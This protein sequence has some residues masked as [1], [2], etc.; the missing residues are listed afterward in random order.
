M[1]T[2]IKINRKEWNKKPFVKSQVS[3]L[4]SNI[5]ESD[6][7]VTLIALDGKLAEFLKVLSYHKLPFTTQ[8]EPQEEKISIKFVGEL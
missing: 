5:R 2:L 7:A 8:V 1:R 4:C 3:S 6:D